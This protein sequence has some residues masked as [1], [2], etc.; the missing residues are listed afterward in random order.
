MTHDT[1]IADFNVGDDYEPIIQVRAMCNEPDA[2]ACGFDVPFC[3]DEGVTQTPGDWW[4]TGA[5]MRRYEQMH[6]EH[7]DNA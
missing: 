4:V 3:D 7:R 1:I 5:D 6:K 2:T